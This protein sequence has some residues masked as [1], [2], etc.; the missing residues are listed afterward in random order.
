MK[1]YEIPRN[2]KIKAK[3][4]SGKDIFI[5]FLHLDGAYSYCVIEDSDPDNVIH[6]SAN[7]PLKK[8][9]DYYEI[10]ESENNTR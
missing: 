4:T 9:G 6:L 3:N 10:D 1:L 8:V 2:S 7:T 5:T